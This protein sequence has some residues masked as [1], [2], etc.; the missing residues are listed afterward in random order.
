MTGPSP[1]SNSDDTPSPSTSFECDI[2]KLLAEGTNPPQLPREHKY[3]VLT[4]EPNPDAAKYPRTR[5]SESD[6]L[7]QFQP[8]RLK[9]Y[10]WL[11]YS[12]SL[13]G[14]FCR[15]CVFFPPS[16]VG[17]QDPGQLVTK[18]SNTWVKMT[19]KAKSHARKEYHLGAMT[20]MSEFIDQYE[21]PTQAVDVVLKSR[22][23]Q[24]VER[25]Q[26][27]IES[28]LK[29]V[30]LCGKQGLALRGH[31]DDGID[32]S[33]ESSSNQSNFVQLVRFRA[34]TDPILARHLAESPKNACYTSK[35]I[36]NELIDVV[37]QS[38]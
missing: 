35:S 10:P 2:G 15:A 37:G 29:I 32:W 6:C 19:A 26:H 30:L 25:N 1:A 38:I 12:A 9:Q 4:T 3:R 27:V 23:Q 13:D 18:P 17:G 7:R 22:L 14:V 33:E 21:N 31:R 34:E 16:Q 5:S 20:K 24:I 36:K 28:L 11:H 8:W